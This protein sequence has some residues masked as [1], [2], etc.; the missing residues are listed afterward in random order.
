MWTGNVK[1]Q[2][3][4]LWYVFEHTNL[5]H[6]LEWWQLQR[7]LRSWLI[8]DNYNWTDVHL[9]CCTSYQ[10]YG[11]EINWR[12][13]KRSECPSALRTTSVMWTG[14][15]DMI[16]H[17]KL[18]CLVLLKWTY[19]TLPSINYFERLCAPNVLIKGYSWHTIPKS[20]FYIAVCHM[21]I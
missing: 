14:T 3:V 10:T 5:K 12:Y 13:S 7:I 6:L 18:S 2:Q 20:N 9:L 8:S 15:A 21:S 1:G 19:D 17:K 16:L 4:K 11:I